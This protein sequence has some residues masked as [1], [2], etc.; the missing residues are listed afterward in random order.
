MMYVNEEMNCS[1]QV[2]R[3]RFPIRSVSLSPGSSKPSSASNAVERV[4]NE[5][6]KNA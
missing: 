6:P 3:P 2:L 4:Q 1:F 5:S